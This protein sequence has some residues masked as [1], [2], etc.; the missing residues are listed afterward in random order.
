MILDDIAAKTRE[1]VAAAKERIG[2]E[3]MRLWAAA[4]VCTYA[5]SHN[6]TGEDLTRIRIKSSI[7]KVPPD[8]AFS[9]EAA[10]ATPGLSFICEVKKASPS[11]GI[12]AVDERFPYLDIAREY[13]DAEASAISVLTEP[14]FF[15]GNNRYLEEIAGVV[16]IPV[17]R[18]DFI[19]DPYQIYEAKALGAQAVLLIAALLDRETL[20]VFLALAAEL[21]LAAL[22]EVHSEVELETV[23]AADP[24]ARIIGVNNRNLQ[25]FEVDLAV[26]GRLRPLIPKDRIVVAESGVRTTED[27]KRLAAYGIDA[28][29][30]GEVFM[31]TADRRELL[32]KMKAAAMEGYR[33]GGEGEP[34]L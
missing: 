34:G 3:D 19:I 25:T 21:E 23:L 17:L 12:I 31:R 32:K 6:I 2:P 7:D 26:T 15:L 1:R 10:L 14:D 11:K 9:F 29:L 30:V 28:L 33:R 18:K 20:S 27:V 16:K 5:N 4:V 8:G 22:T 13:E 24:P